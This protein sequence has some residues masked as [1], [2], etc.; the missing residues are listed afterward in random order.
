MMQAHYLQRLTEESRLQAK[1]KQTQFKANTNPNKANFSPKIRVA[2]PIQTQYKPNTNP[3][4]TQK[5][6]YQSQ[7]NP[8]LAQKLG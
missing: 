8:I 6:G 3:I 7:T 1:S 2:N 5:S 4:L